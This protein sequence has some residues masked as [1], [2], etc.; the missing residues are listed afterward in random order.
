MKRATRAA[1][2]ASTATAATP[3]ATS[4]PAGSA[5]APR[6]SAPRSRRPPTNTP[7]ITPT[8]SIT[9]TPSRTWTPSRTPTVNQDDHSRRT[10]V[11]TDVCPGSV[12]LR[13]R[14]QCAW[15]HLGAGCGERADH[16][17]P[18]LALRSRSKPD[19]TRPMVILP[20]ESHFD[21][22]STAAAGIS[23]KLCARLDPTTYCHGGP[24][25]GLACPP[26]VCGAGHPCDINPAHG[27]VDCAPAAAASR[28]RQLGADRSQHEPESGRRPAQPWVAGGPEL[29]ATRLSLRWR[30]AGL[31]SR[32]DRSRR[33]PARPTRTPACATAQSNRRS[34]ASLRQA[35]SG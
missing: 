7:T 11:H 34:P 25:D 28:G 16:R 10:H 22:A 2:T 24:N 12:H 29:H 21:C 14:D 4:S 18:G 27:M 32:G 1:A 35:A 8:P 15:W 26:A 30:G 33:A 23:V 5:P 6:R 20:S 3:A 31:L 13:R 19:S 9:R 17:L